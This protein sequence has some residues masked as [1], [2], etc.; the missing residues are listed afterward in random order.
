MRDLEKRIKLH[1]EFWDG[2]PLSEPVVSYKIGDYFFADKFRANL[3]LLEKGTISTTDMVDVDAYMVDYE[4]MYQMSEKTGQTGFFTAEPNTGIPWIEGMVGCPI[5]GEEVAFMGM[6]ILD[7]INDVSDLILEDNNPWLLKYLEFVEKLVALSKGRF[8]VGQ[9]IMRGSTDVLGCLI[10]Q[11][12]MALAVMIEPEKTKKLFNQVAEMLR[13]IIYEQFKRV[14]EFYGGYAAG[15]YHLWSPGKQI[16]YQEDLS[17]I[18]SPKHYDEFLKETS[19]IICKGYDYTFVHLHPNSFFHLDGI[20]KQ[21]LLKAVQINKDV[22]G[23]TV[24]EMI[25]VFRRVYDANKRLIVWGDLTI[26]ETKMLMEELP[27]HSLFMNIVAPT[28]EYAQELQEII[29]SKWKK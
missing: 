8:P 21:P 27:Q 11:S 5:Q 23:P 4:E 10:G 17:A 18:L 26:D 9:P 20:L 15:F 24:E 6:P 16:W 28:V 2:A 1:R 29:S 14:P 25:P 3:P 7:D 19:E 13:K 22:S 12:N